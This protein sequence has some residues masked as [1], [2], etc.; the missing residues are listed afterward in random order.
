MIDRAIAPS[1]NQL[2]FDDENNDI[3]HFAHSMTH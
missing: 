1:I 3:E 2:P